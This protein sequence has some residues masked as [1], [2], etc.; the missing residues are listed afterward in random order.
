[1]N[2]RIGLLLSYHYYQRMSLSQALE[3]TYPGLPVM[4][5]SGA[6]SAASL[7]VEIDL[8][9]YGRW[10]R[11]NGGKNVCAI[12]LDVIGD[13]TRSRL[14]L[15]RLSRYGDFMPVVHV[16]SPQ[17]DIDRYV[18]R[19][20]KYIGLG[21]MV[22]YLCQDKKGGREMLIR[23]MSDSHERA[24]KLGVHLHGLGCTTWDLVLR[25][26]WYSVDSSF[27]NAG[28]RF[29][30]SSVWDRP[31]HRWHKITIRDAGSIMPVADTLRSYGVNPWPL[32]HDSPDTNGQLL[33]TSV[34]SVRAWQED[35]KETPIIY[36][37]EGYY[38]HT[39]F[40]ANRITGGTSELIPKW[41][42]G[43]T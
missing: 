42:E 33:A 43:L 19:G 7:G 20:H 10:A 37:A 40:L 34:E 21:G 31:N 9:K 27:H 1:M 36:M 12:N 13:A 26:P 32:L 24:T 15:T 5:D 22:P 2:H 16:G 38:G 18:D 39:A 4:L 28:I 29:G 41:A 14:N 23:W 8:D 11:T 35:K 17:D 3:G 25:F 6:F 30:A